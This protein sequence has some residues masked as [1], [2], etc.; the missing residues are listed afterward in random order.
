MKREGQAKLENIPGN[1]GAESG[2]GFLA[3]HVENEKKVENTHQEEMDRAELDKVRAKLEQEM[4]N[5]PFAPGEV[6]DPEIEIGKIRQGSGEERR[7]N[8]ETFKQKLIYQKKGLAQ[9]E[10]R[11][12]AEI[13]KNPTVEAVAL[14]DILQELG[15][16]FALSESQREKFSVALE[17]YF[18]RRQAV[19]EYRERCIG[20]DGEVDGGRLYKRLFGKSPSGEVG[21]VMKPAEIHLQVHDKADYAY[22]VSGANL[23]HG[24]LT[25]SDL[26]LADKSRGCVAALAETTGLKNAVLVE[27]FS[28]KS[29]DI[30]FERTFRH[31]SQH[32]TNSLTLAVF[33][34]ERFEEETR[35][36]NEISAYFKSGLSFEEIR[37]KILSSDTVYDYG[38]DY[39]NEKVGWWDKLKQ[40]V[41]GRKT[42]SQEYQRLVENGIQAFDALLKAGY[43]TEEVQAL[44]FKESLPNWPK[45]AGWMRGE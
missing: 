11:L 13:E 29:E 20:E 12:W 39:K 31:E 27:N 36:K 40:E 43:S 25:G 44:I 41:L 18:S 32:A 15:D 33:A 35:I 38:F 3:T 24:G 8:L 16:K 19:Q 7:Q 6:F 22:L 21:V 14:K 2:E 9:I 10:N 5:N 30:N 45:V 4:I 37:E 23:V 1:K 42:F 34:P 28:K 26:T 17:I